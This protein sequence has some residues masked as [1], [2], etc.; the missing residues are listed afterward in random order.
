MKANRM[1]LDEALRPTK[2][3]CGQCGSDDFTAYPAPV[4]EGTGFCPACSPAWLESFA[5]FMMNEERAKYG[6]EAC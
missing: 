3:T 2:M 4:P 1:T 5:T 6:L